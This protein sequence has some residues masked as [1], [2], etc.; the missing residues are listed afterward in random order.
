MNAEDDLV[1]VISDAL[2]LR[3]FHEGDE[4]SFEA[5][6]Q[7]H[8]DMVYGVLFRLTGT[9]AQAEDLAQE[10]FLQ[11]YRRPLRHG[12]NVAG[13]LYRVAINT[14]YNALRAEH[15]RDR[16]ERIAASGEGSA[17][18]G[19]EEE[20]TRR[21]LQQ[22]VRRALARMPERAGKM[23][24][25]RESGFSYREVA[26]IV[27]VAPGSIGTLLARAQEAFIR[28]YEDEGKEPQ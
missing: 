1:T 9:R 26:E 22:R 5:L 18:P 20:V 15:R 25:L 21:D 17:I 2:L 4:A 24:I 8:Y 10:V 14:G 11:L 3:R 28:A 27:G 13:W 23:L 16:R 12:E 7:R 6:F 19:P